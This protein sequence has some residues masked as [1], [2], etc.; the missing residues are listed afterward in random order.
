MA[1]VRVREV[2]DDRLLAVCRAAGPSGSD[3]HLRA[4]LLYRRAVLEFRERDARWRRDRAARLVD[5]ALREVAGTVR[6]A[7]M[8]RRGLAG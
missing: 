7:V 1:D 5:E 4:C 2:S 8:V 6:M 3:A